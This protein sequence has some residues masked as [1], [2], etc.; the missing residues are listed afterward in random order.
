[1]HKWIGPFY[2]WKDER[3]NHPLKP[4][5]CISFD[6]ALAYSRWAHEI[7]ASEFSGSF[8]NLVPYTLWDFAA[9]GTE[10][11][12]RDPKLWNSSL[13]KIHHKH[14]APSVIDTD[15]QR[16]NERGVTDLLGN[17]WEWCGS[18]SAFLNRCGFEHH[19][20]SKE[21]ICLR[22]GGFLDD[23]DKVIPFL[24]EAEIPDRSG[25]CHSDHGFRIASLIPVDL[26]PPETRRQLKLF[27]PIELEHRIEISFLAGEAGDF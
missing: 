11:P 16:M 12:S 13:E 14:M 18:M 9:F 26:L 15:G 24:E 21:K 5:V 3:F 1:V 7:A 17:V 25:S 8:T 23:L 22:G 19:R 4:V 27:P 10:Y 6:Q 20:F 2:P